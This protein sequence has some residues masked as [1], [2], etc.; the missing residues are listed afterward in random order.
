MKHKTKLNKYRNLFFKVEK[1]R[2]CRIHDHTKQMFIESSTFKNSRSIF[3]QPALKAGRYVAIVCTF[4]PNIQGEFLF[5][6]YSSSA[7]NFK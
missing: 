7:S 6:M 2:R 5:R 1:N 3:L 4:D